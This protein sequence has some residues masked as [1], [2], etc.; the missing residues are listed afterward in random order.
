MKNDYLNKL[1]E[2][3][4]RFDM[5]ETEKLDIISDYDDMYE[6]W[7]DCGMSEEEVELKLGKPNKIIG[8]LTEGYKKIQKPIGKGGKFIAITPFIATIAFFII[9]FG[10]NGWVYGWMVF[11]L[12]PVSAIIIEMG[13]SDK[14]HITTALSPFIATVGYFILGFYYNLWHPGWIIFLI[15]P[16]LGVFNSRKD[17]DFKTLLTS[18][19]PFAAVIIFVFLGEEGLWN[20][21]W[22]IFLIIP[23]FGLLHDHNKGRMMLNFVLIL[24]GVLGYLYVFEYTDFHWAYGLIAFAPLVILNIING[25]IQITGGDEVPLGYKLVVISAVVS[26]FIISFATG[27]W[28]ISWLVFL[29][30]PVY[31]ISRETD[32]NAKVISLTPFI[33]VTIFML[34]G[35]FFNLWAWAWLAF[36]IIPVTAIIKEG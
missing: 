27:W 15:I 22:L 20:P 11:L 30:I 33:A 21:G 7:L 32:G 6:N 2:Q 28:V 14:E 1:R 9:G 4:D 12:I 25:N 16:I 17:M 19:S 31:A 29:A 10:F 26:Y 8:S 23:S 5:E 13:K 18:L 35:F 24:V 36:L 3:L 34:L